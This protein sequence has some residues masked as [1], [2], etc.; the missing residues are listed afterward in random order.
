[1]GCRYVLVH[2]QGDIF[3]FKNTLET[4]TQSAIPSTFRLYFYPYFGQLVNNPG[5]YGEMAGYV[6]IL[7]AAIVKKTFF[8]NEQDLLSPKGEGPTAFA[9]A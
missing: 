3:Y 9:Q 7:I 4:N 5:R 2:D 1:M 6:K 8:V